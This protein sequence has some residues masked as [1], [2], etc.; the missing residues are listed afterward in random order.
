M[1]SLGDCRGR[2]ISERV[3]RA[4]EPYLLGGVGHRF[5]YPDNS[6]LIMIKS[7]CKNNVPEVFEYQDGPA[8][9]SPPQSQRCDDRTLG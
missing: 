7:V 3:V 2:E 1:H 4:R 6:N 5:A 9:S 8:P